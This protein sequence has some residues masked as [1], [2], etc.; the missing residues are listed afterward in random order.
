MKAEIETKIEYDVYDS[1]LNQFKNST[2]YHSK[3]FLIF[4]E[5]LLNLNAYCITAKDD[6]KIVG[7]LPFF[8]KDSPYG[9][10]VN[11][12]P[13]F[14]SYGGIISEN[15]NEIKNKILEQMNIFNKENDVL[16]SVIISNPFDQDNSSYEKIFKHDI[17]QLRRIQCTDLQGYDKETLMQSLE[18]R[19]RW[20]IRKSDKLLV[21]VTNVSSQKDRIEDFYKMHLNA[22][23]RKSGKTKPDE[24]FN[25]IGKFFT[26]GEDFDIL[27]A[28]IDS[29]YIGYLL[30]FYHGQFAEYY[31]PAFDLN[32][33]TAQATSAL[34]WQ[35]MLITMEK[36][37]RYYNFGG[38]W[39]TQ[40][41]VY[42][43]KRGWGA[44]DFNHIYYIYRDLKRLKEI[45]LDEIKTKFD[46]FFVVPY[47]EI[48]EP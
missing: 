24:F 21:K 3:K 43:F 35:S 26:P 44:Q 29:Q 27:A 37:I 2:F 38:T 9:K 22:M 33:K 15:N 42:L 47:E 23:G 10:V 16:S 17:K 13:F 4:L 7:V 28:S 12:L 45:G 40:H 34:T 25:K 14:G 20:S 18:K 5:N 6:G 11:S 46:Y 32:W 41:E 48:N 8:V 36:K 31:I 30:V 39:S 1:F 19:T